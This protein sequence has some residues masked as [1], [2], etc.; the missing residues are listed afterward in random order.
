M[1]GLLKITSQQ[2]A[3]LKNL[4]LKIGDHSYD[5]VP[6]AQIFPRAL[7]KLLGGHPDSIYLV[8]GDLGSNTPGLDFIDGYVF[9]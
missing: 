8:V 9:L 7:N 3:N 5:L 2:Y 1:T 6:N 4:T